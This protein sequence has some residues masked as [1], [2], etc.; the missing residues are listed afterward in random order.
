MNSGLVKWKYEHDHTYIDN[1]N[2]SWPISNI[3]IIVYDG[4]FV[5][6]KIHWLHTTLCSKIS[7][8]LKFLN[9]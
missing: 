4:T 5:C 7:V 2:F 9:H 6:H 1:T 3:M 8:K